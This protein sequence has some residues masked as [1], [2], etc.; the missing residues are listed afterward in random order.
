MTKTVAVGQ[1]VSASGTVLL[2]LFVTPS[3]SPLHRI[4]WAAPCATTPHAPALDMTSARVPLAL[5]RAAPGWLHLVI[6]RRRVTT[7]S[8]PNAGYTHGVATPRESTPFASSLGWA[9][10]CCRQVGVGAGCYYACLVALCLVAALLEAVVVARSDELLVCTYL[11]F[12]SSNSAAA[13]WQGC[14]AT[15]LLFCRGSVCRSWCPLVACCESSVIACLCVFSFGRTACRPGRQDQDLGRAG[16][17]QV[18]AHLP[19]SLQGCEGHQLHKRWPQVCQRRLRQEY[20]AV[21]HRDRPGEADGWDQ[22]TWSAA[23]RPCRPTPSTS[24]SMLKWGI[25]WRISLYSKARGPDPYGLQ[26]VYVGDGC[27]GCVRTGLWY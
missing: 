3:P 8:F 19:G 1:F 24:S 16:Q 25:R 2:P 4:Y 18:H 11:L 27:D 13:A 7:A 17:L 6:R 9:S 5:C 15:H 21:G 22:A 23:A 10:C 12:S 20:P 26:D 14:F